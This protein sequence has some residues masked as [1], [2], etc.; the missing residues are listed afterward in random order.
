MWKSWYALENS[1]VG[2][3]ASIGRRKLGTSQTKLKEV[4]NSEFADGSALADTL[5]GQDAA[6]FCLGAYTARCRTRSS[7]R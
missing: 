6:V 5:P 4:L 1:A 3:V 7:E 2:C